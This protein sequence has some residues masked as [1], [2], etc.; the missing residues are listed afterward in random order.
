MS[1]N[2]VEL[3]HARTELERFL[4]DRER[5]S[6]SCGRHDL[7]NACLLTDMANATICIPNKQ[8]S[9][10]SAYNATYAGRMERERGGGLHACMQ[11]WIASAMHQCSLQQ[12]P[13]YD[14]RRPS[15]IP[16]GPL[17]DPLPSHFR[18]C[19]GRKWSLQPASNTYSSCALES[20][21]TMHTYTHI[22]EPPIH[23]RPLHLDLHAQKSMMRMLIW[24]VI[25]LPGNIFQWILE[26][27]ERRI[28][29]RARR[30]NVAVRVG[31]LR[32]PVHALRLGLCL[33]PIGAATKRCW[34]NE[35]A[36]RVCRSFSSPS[37]SSLL[38]LLRK[39]ET[40]LLS[41]RCSRPP[42]NPSPT[43][44]WRAQCS[45]R[46]SERARSEHLI[47]ASTVFCHRHLL[48]LFRFEN[49]VPSQICVRK[50]SVTWKTGSVCFC[51][52]VGLFSLGFR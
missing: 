43:Q 22:E 36:A 52:R 33:S 50:G 27:L 15:S 6:P 46:V 19:R 9:Q 51:T 5:R 24:R 35:I 2:A 49:T 11:V 14:H 44:K 1:V 40:C 13:A 45:H 39:V 23:P 3:L 26:L 32:I 16:K 42:H 34:R 48:R 18:G 7:A 21:V 25:Y 37:P 47:F 28:K 20:T 17:A 31:G 29:H 41:R 4:I 10:Q 30:A 38:P 12:P 8:Q